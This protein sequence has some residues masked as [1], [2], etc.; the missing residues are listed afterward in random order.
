MIFI[1]LGANL[2]SPR[3]GGPQAACEAALDALRRA[4][5]RIK[6]RS[7]WYRSAPV[8]PSDQPWFINGVAEVATDLSPA[9]LLALLHRTERD[10]GRVRRAR[11]EPR[12]IDLDLLSYGDRVSA[13]GETPI[14]PHPRLAERAFVVLPLAELAP[15]W[16]HPESGLTAAELAR[17]L[18]PDQAAEP[19]D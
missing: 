18:P 6:R 2:P 19:V 7:R 17:C 8:P 13:A 1:G 16:R 10:F 12:I 15:D 11:N 3:H 9:D 5:L 14:L 4:G